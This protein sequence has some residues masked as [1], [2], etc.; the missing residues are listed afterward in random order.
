MVEKKTA[1]TSG[2]VFEDG[3]QFAPLDVEGCESGRLKRIR[4]FE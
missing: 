1:A 2:G 3:I 4:L